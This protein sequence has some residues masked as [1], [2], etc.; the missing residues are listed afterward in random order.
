MKDTISQNYSKTDS[1]SPNLVIMAKRTSSKELS[2]PH[3]DLPFRKTRQTRERLNK[4]NSRRRRLRQPPV[5]KQHNIGSKPGSFLNQVLEF[6]LL[7]QLPPVL[8]T[9]R[10][11]HIP[12]TSV[13]LWCCFVHLTSSSQEF[14]FVPVV[15]GE[16][17]EC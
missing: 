9:N 1:N 10:D 13:R 12:E 15:L 6:F 4:T 14:G 8:L 3:L 5:R 2:Q 7:T 16:R 17:D 11:Y